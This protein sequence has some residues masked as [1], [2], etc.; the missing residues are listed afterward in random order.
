MPNARDMVNV[1]LPVPLRDLMARER[2][3]DRQALH[4]IIEE[5]FLFWK[6]RGGWTPF[7][8]LPKD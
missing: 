1:A 6:D 4:E 8:G 7:R 3:H 2:I 5:A